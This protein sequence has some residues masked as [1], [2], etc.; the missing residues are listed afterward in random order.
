MLLLL[1]YVVCVTDRLEQDS[2]SFCERPNFLLTLQ[3]AFCG[4]K[5]LHLYASLTWIPS[6][7]LY[8]AML[9]VGGKHLTMNSDNS[10]APLPSVASIISY[11]TMVASAN[12]SWT[13]VTADYG[14]YYDSKIPRCVDCQS[15]YNEC[16]T[17]MGC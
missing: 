4:Y 13:T 8:L 16:M 5:A 12:V 17:D 2:P 6:A 3:V 11:G 10:D 9:V 14:V 7:F 15:V 1:E